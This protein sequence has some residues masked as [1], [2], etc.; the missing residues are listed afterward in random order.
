MLELKETGTVS[1]VNAAYSQEAALPLKRPSSLQYRAD[2]DG[3]R[4]I[5]VLLV[6]LDHL[7][8]RFTGGYVGV[9]VFFVISGYL[10]SSTILA[11]MAAGKFSILNFY[12]RRVRRIFPA[13]LVVLIV[14]A[15]FAAHYLVPSE[16]E[17][18]ARS[19]LA[20]LFSVSNFVFWRQ[21]GYFDL[22]SALKPLL[23]TW[24][25]AVEEQFYIFFPLLLVVVRR[26][27]QGRIRAAIF[28]VTVVTFVLAC[29]WV[30][31]DAPTAFF[32]AP[33][34]AWELL[35][36]TIVSQHYFPALKSTVQRNV[37][38]FA[39]L[40]LI[41]VPSLL[42]TG[43]TPFPGAAALFPCVGAALIIMAGESGGSFV[44]KLLTWRPMVFIGGISYSLYLWHWPV[45]VF[46]RTSFMLVHSPIDSKVTK[47]AVLLVSLI[48]AS[49]SWKYVETP[50]RRGRLRPD[51][52][53]LFVINGLAMAVIVVVGVLLIT[54]KGLAYRFSPQALAIANYAAFDPAVAYRQ[55]SCFLDPDQ[56]F[57]DF[58]QP[59]CLKA[60]PGKKQYLLYGDSHAA[61]LYPGL[62]KV[63]PGIAIQQANI[64]QCRPFL[65]E[66]K[67]AKKGCVALSKF[68]F[69]DYLVH[70]KVDAV[71]LAGRWQKDEIPEL[72]RTVAWLKQH[73]IQVV[74]FGPVIEYDLALP[75][76]IA[77]AYR[78]K[79]NGEVS[80]HRSL[81]PEKL[82][83][84]LATIA[85]DQWKVRYISIY[86][87]LCSSVQ[88]TAGLNCPIYA[89]SE[90]PLLFDTNHLTPAGSIEYAKAME[91]KG[92]IP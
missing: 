86:E 22:P 77:M 2:I 26:W 12:E 87:D 49:L 35:I 68:M 9:D 48:L 37:G 30:M 52:T 65:A 66:T 11:E 47:A 15:G 8:T 54:T 72:G 55:K 21:S 40:F 74:L 14:T 27:M 75:R 39:G 56:P 38:A 42:Y 79:N 50:F 18:F 78:D 4:A 25:L 34:R 59:V 60:D 91:A 46:Q 67:S 84:Q 81:E 16:L 51:R 61:Q 44:G 70:H 36:G 1:D 17:S 83:G 23:H 85:R 13:L 64:A 33:L 76:I 28:T 7:G 43:Q 41:L 58:N 88:K 71:L 53:K 20:A 73:G 24:S 29:I 5:A 69:D 57:S 80:Q 90:V 82:D 63:F 92:Q 45:L 31:R 3:M 32:L 19:M 6:I 62:A 89:G 10:I